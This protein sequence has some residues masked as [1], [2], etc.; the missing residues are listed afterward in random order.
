MKNTKMIIPAVLLIILDI[1]LIIIGGFLIH[2]VRENFQIGTLLITI[3][4][5]L[6]SGVCGATARILLE[7]SKRKKQIELWL[8]NQNDDIKKLIK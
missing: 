3:F 6:L 7:T 2:S 5:I 4:V 8:K 1:I